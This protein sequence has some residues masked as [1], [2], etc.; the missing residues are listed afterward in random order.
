MKER[1][2]KERGE[3]KGKGGKG[4]GG[5]GG[6]KREGKDDLG[7][8]WKGKKMREEGGGGEETPTNPTIYSCHFSIWYLDTGFDTTALQ[9]TCAQAAL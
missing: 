3:R 2:E 7:K 1:K 4:R 6:N 9:D 5:E 8:G